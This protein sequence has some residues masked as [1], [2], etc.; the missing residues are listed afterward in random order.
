[1]VTTSSKSQIESKKA[2]KWGIE[3][4]PETVPIHTWFVSEHCTV[5]WLV[6]I[7]IWFEA[8]DQAYR[9][10]FFNTDSICLA[11]IWLK[12]V[13]FWGNISAWGNILAN[14]VTECD[15]AISNDGSLVIATIGTLNPSDSKMLLSASTPSNF[16]LRYNW[17]IPPE[18]SMPQLPLIDKTKKSGDFHYKQSW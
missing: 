3:T 17:Y 2:I 15:G 8:T 13:S 7:S 11:R 18:L 14:T 9:D 12:W 1:M 5:S 6:V 4:V 10:W 16:I